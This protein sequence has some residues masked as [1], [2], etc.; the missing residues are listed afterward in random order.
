MGNYFYPGGVTNTF[1]VLL[2]K[3]CNKQK[4]YILDQIHQLL[5][6]KTKFKTVQKVSAGRIWPTGRYLPTP[7]PALKLNLQQRPECNPVKYILSKRDK[8]SLDFIL[9]SQYWL[10][11]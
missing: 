2:A 9:F 1:W 4:Q 10:Q 6:E 3:I 8:I 11:Q 7:A 5:V